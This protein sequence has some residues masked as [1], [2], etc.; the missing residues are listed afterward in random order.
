MIENQAKTIE[1]I[2]LNSAGVVEVSGFETAVVVERGLPTSSIQILREQG[3][4]F[5][6]VHE[7]ILP[8][9]TLKHRQEKNQLLTLDEADRVLRVAKVMTLADHVFGDHEKA[10][11]WLRRMNNRLRG[12]APID[13]LRSEV[14][15]DLVRQMLF[16]IDEGIF[17]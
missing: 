7:L 11:G 2:L 9:R 17:V 14:G 16:Q 6:E 4:T 1:A 10:L 12:R 3:L 13:M 8:A 5:G 15:G